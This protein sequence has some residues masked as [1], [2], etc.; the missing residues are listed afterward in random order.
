MYV[1]LG[2]PHG[3]EV[4]SS[5]TLEIAAACILLSDFSSSVSAGVA[6]RFC[7]G[8]LRIN[9]SAIV[10]LFRVCISCSSERT[11]ARNLWGPGHNFLTR[12]MTDVAVEQRDGLPLDKR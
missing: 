7:S 6:S 9:N 2:I 5:S 3:N 12:E 1:L 4:V 8:A 10:G 11:R